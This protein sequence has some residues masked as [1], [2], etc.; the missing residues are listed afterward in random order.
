LKERT[1]YLSTSG[2]K[3]TR[4]GTPPG[5]TYDVELT[6]VGDDS[7]QVMKVIRDITGLSFRET[8]KF[9]ESVPNVLAADVSRA[10][11]ASLKAKFDRLDVVIS[12]RPRF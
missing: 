2:A 8:Q 6:E 4:P 1:H 11:A 3:P 9:V 10:A 7:F 5:T 12:V